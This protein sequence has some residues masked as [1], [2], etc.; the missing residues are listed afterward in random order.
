MDETERMETMRRL[1]IKRAMSSCL[2]LIR[3]TYIT[4]KE[5]DEDLVTT[6]E[7]VR[8]DLEHEIEELERRLLPHHLS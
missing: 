8:A 2:G 6:F 3:N 4:Y 7:R 1:E 5:Y